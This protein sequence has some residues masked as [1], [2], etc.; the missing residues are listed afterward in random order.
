MPVMEYRQPGTQRTKS[1]DAFDTQI[2]HTRAFANQL[3]EHAEYQRRGDAEYRSPQAGG[4]EKVNR[5]VH[6][7]TR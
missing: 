4:E 1:H 6:R 7:R 5:F 2:H 3:T